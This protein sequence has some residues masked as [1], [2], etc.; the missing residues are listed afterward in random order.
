M[1]DTPF[2]PLTG[3]PDLLETKAKHYR[4]IAA[5]IQRSTK[6]LKSIHDVDNTKSEATDALKKQADDVRTDIDKAHDRY[7]TTATAL[8]SYASSLRAAQ[9]DAQ[10]AITAIES[11]SS[12]YDAAVKRSDHAMTYAYDTRWKQEATL[13]EKQ[14]AADEADRASRHLDD[15]KGELNA[16]HQKW[17]DALRDKRSAAK[18]ARAAIDDV[19]EHHNNGLADPTGLEKFLEGVYKVFKVICDIAGVLA[20]FLAWVPFLGQVLI[21]L[22]AVGALL[23]I[24]EAVIKVINGTGDG[25]GI[26]FAV[27]GA[28]VT[29]FG[30]KLFAFAAKGLRAMTIAKSGATSVRELALLQGLGRHSA[31]LMKRSDAL[32]QLQKPLSS[33]FKSPFVRE[34]EQ[35]AI[36]A[37]FA[38]GEKGFTE[39][40]AEAAKIAFP[41]FKIDALK[42][43]GFSRDLEL[44]Q[45]M[46]ASHPELITQEMKTLYLAAASYNVLAIAD[47]TTNVIQNFANDP[48]GTSLGFVDGEAKGVWSGVKDTATDWGKLFPGATSTVAP[49]APGSYSEGRVLA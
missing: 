45:R 48:V 29:L 2:K 6:A 41:G 25:W 31:D 34:A 46:A 49:G 19:V 9:A 12:T 5:A 16:A 33:V 39:S 40:L 20:I 7:D 17:Y 4:E 38:R 43:L 23:D 24:L 35:Q 26:V 22:A 8:I 36:T 30:G 1:S 10:R 15:A 32:A 11:A 21:V 13:E 18:T 47:K 27:A 42:T 3:D 28:A 44:F 14:N 37:A